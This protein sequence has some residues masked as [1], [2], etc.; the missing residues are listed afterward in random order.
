MLFEIFTS[1]YNNLKIKPHIKEFAKIIAV[2]KWE[3]PYLSELGFKK[4]KII[5]IP[6]GLSKEFFIQ[7]YTIKKINCN[8]FI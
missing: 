6:N 4:E 2:T 5:Y 8:K 7:K 1:V 3:M